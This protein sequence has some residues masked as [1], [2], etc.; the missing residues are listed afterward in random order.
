[1]KEIKIIFILDGERM[2]VTIPEPPDDWETKLSHYCMHIGNIASYISDKV[3]KAR[4][5]K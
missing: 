5:L 4:G 1:M 2:E 3:L